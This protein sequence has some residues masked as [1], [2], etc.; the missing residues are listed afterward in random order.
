MSSTYTLLHL[1]DEQEVEISIKRKAEEVEP[2]IIS[3]M[4][5][6]LTENSTENSTES[7]VLVTIQFPPSTSLHLA[8]VDVA[9]EV[10]M[11][12]SPFSLATLSL[13]NLW[14]GVNLQVEPKDGGSFVTRGAPAT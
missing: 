1:T 9:V 10:V 12:E 8:D 2:V 4:K 6:E 3:D 14:E 7:P 11:T 13:L 5:A